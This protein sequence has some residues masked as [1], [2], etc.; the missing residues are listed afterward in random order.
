MIKRMCQNLRDETKNVY[1]L[2]KTRIHVS[3][4]SEREFIDGFHRLYHETIDTFGTTLWHGVPTYKFPQ[5]LWIYQEI[6]HEVRPDLIVECGTSFG[7]S[8][9]YM[10]HVLDQIGHGEI[11][12]IDT[13]DMVRKYHKR[14]RY[15]FGSSTGIEISESIIEKAKNNKVLVILDSDHSR[16]HVLNEMNIYG[17][18]VSVGSYM[19]V[20][21][22]DLGGH[23]VEKEPYN[24]PYEAIHEFMDRNDSFRIDK[25]REKFM[26]TQN[27]DGFLK[28]IK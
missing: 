11:I 1:H 24:G 3:S 19:I 2:F 5:D 27:V 28:R 21:D 22:S 6:I 23:P 14:I 10:A 12:T 7:G 9:L 20:E 16:K 25:S 8:A 26:V 18:L 15:L 4:E 17:K 13:Q